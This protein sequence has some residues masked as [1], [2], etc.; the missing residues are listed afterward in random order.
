VRK[1]FETLDVGDAARERIFSGTACAW[2][3]LH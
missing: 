3:G 1:L 2:L